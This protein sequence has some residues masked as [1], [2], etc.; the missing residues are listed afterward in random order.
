M[1]PQRASS[2]AEQHLPYAM[3]EFGPGGSPSVGDALSKVRER[4]RQGDALFDIDGRVV[5]AIAGGWA[6]AV[7]VA[8]RL[9]ED[10]E[11]VRD[12]L[13]PHVMD[14]HRAPVDIDLTSGVLHSRDQGPAGSDPVH[15]LVVDDDDDVRRVLTALMTHEGWRVTD[16]GN[17]DDALQ[18]L[19]QITFDV[20]VSDSDVPPV[21][22]VGFART[23]RARGD[24]TP[25]LV[26]SGGSTSDLSAAASA[27]GF[28]IVPKPATT[29]LIR[30]IGETLRAR[31]PAVG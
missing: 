13:V 30:L 2:K 8:D 7:A 6:S 20:I 18:L 29:T 23:L 25:L 27:A 24:S 28:R 5:A 4:V 26:F 17:A 3:I 31:R 15:V 14:D 11:L 16:V 12:G 1:E 22:G 10:P 9:R 19:T 21:R